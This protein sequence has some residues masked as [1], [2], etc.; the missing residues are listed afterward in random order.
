MGLLLPI[1]VLYLWYPGDADETLFEL[2]AARL[3]QGAVYYRDVWD[4]KQPGI[5]WIYQFGA[6]LGVGVVGTRLVEIAAVV[7][8]GWMV[9]RLAGNWRLQRDARILAPALVM[10]LY[11]LYTHHGGVAE[12]EGFMTPLLVAVVALV[13]P[14]PPEGGAPRPG[15]RWVAA[16]LVLGVIGVLKVLYQPLPAL[17]IIGAL[18]ASRAPLRTLAGRAALVAA[19]GAVPLLVMIGYFAAH[20]V[21][22]LFWVTT[23]VVPFET[24]GRSVM[25]SNRHH[26]LE[27]ALAQGTLLV[28][29]AVVAV[30]TA[31]RRGTLVREVTLVTTLVAAAVL[32]Y[33][34]YP[35]PYRLLILMAPLGLLAIT[36][37]DVVLCRRTARARL[38]LLA[39][40]ALLLLPSMRGPQR[41]LFAA[42]DV[43]SWGLGV[44]DRNARDEVLISEYAGRD[45]APVR[46]L[47]RPGA[48]MY[49]IGHPQPYQLLGTR[50]A[51]EVSGWGAATQPPRVWAERDRE[52]VR[53]RPEWVFVESD[54]VPL[55]RSSAPRF[56]AVLEESYRKVASAPR[57][58]WYRTDAP[59]TPSGIPGDN[60]L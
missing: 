8:G 9:W 17:L 31:R 24:A 43:P 52:L 44:A 6:S 3:S 59:G 41:L 30:L 26:Y 13:W 4:I 60:R 18:V 21:G 55:V 34:Q 49:V 25:D 2:T 11:L 40:A 22:R 33:P 57:G 7:L 12:I 32:A 42:P 38:A 53:S 37:A 39:L 15:W 36:G 46:A 27:M 28:P 10:G 47:V 19:G 58:T 14:R 45:V 50:E 56:A 29:L 1:C 48:S 16:G 23:F 35:T 5:Y 54:M 20:G 51:I